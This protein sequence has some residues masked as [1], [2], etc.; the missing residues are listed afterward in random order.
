[1]IASPRLHG[2]IRNV[3]EDVGAM[4]KFLVIPACLIRN[5]Q[6]GLCKKSSH[7]KAQ[8]TASF[9]QQVAAN[10]HGMAFY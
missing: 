10:I 1:M 9:S 8:L 3:F 6:F 2:T 7:M 5:K 4:Y